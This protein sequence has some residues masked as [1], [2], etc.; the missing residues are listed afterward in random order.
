LAGSKQIAGG[1]TDSPLPAAVQIHES[2]FASGR[3]HF[4]K[5]ASTGDDR[6]QKLWPKQVRLE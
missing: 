4:S 6:T 1:N 5:F 2:V 3:R